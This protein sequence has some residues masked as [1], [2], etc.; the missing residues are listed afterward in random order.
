ML[1]CEEIIT[2]WCGPHQPYDNKSKRV[3]NFTRQFGCKVRSV[4]AIVYHLTLEDFVNF[5]KMVPMQ[6]VEEAFKDR[7]SFLEKQLELENK[8]SEQIHCLQKKNSEVKVIIQNVSSELIPSRNKTAFQTAPKFERLSKDR[9]TITT[10]LMPSTE[11]MPS[12]YITA[13]QE[14]LGKKTIAINSVES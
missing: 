10:K 3:G 13:S 4:K 14:S 6:I 1:G 5:L 2:D 9:S 7:F 11:F 8:V 12:Q